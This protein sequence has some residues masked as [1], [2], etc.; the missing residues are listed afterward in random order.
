MQYADLDVQEAVL[1]GAEVLAFHP[2]TSQPLALMWPDGRLSFNS[3][4]YSQSD[5]LE[6]S[7]WIAGVIASSQ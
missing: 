4:Y 1:C 2:R 5:A 7:K 3:T 6:L